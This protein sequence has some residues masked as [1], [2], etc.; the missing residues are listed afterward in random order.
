MMK[1]I[2]EGLTFHHYAVIWLTCIDCVQWR[3]FY[4]AH[5][6]CSRTCHFSVTKIICGLRLY[7]LPA[8]LIFLI[9]NFFFSIPPPNVILSFY[10]IFFSFLQRKEVFFFRFSYRPRILRASLSRF[11]PLI[12]TEEVGFLMAAVILST[13]S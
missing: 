12:C 2:I 3:S 4:P 7:D 8:L 6:H 1:D 10:L 5:Y 9:L 13:L 11:V